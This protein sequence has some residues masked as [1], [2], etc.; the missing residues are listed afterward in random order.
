MHIALN[1]ITGDIA[2]NEH[3]RH[4]DNLEFSLHRYA[5]KATDGDSSTCSSTAEPNSS[6]GRGRT[7][8]PFWKVWFPNPE[9]I[10]GMILRTKKG[11]L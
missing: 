11:G 4:L 7:S 6:V 3:S 1:F 5:D 9:L 2:F 8:E 10:S